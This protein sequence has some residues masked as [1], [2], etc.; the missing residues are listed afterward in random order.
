[1]SRRVEN[2]YHTPNFRALEREAP[3]PPLSM[4]KGEGKRHV[5]LA[6][7]PATSFGTFSGFFP[8]LIKYG[9]H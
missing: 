8:P 3:F 6:A 2:A 7:G 4:R 5:L 1:V 9:F